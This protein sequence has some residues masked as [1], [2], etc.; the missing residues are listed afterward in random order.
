MHRDQ[1]LQQGYILAHVVAEPLLPLG[2]RAAIKTT[3]HVKHRQQRKADTCLFRRFDQR[4]RHGD[5]LSYLPSGV[6]L[7]DWASEAEKDP[8]GFTDRARESMA[9]HVEGM[10]GF[11]D[12]G[13]EVF[14]TNSPSRSR[15]AA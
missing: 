1:L 12:S 15:C 8:E 5:P 3:G 9:R 14:A 4:Q 13:A 7:E 6:A 11:Q 10:V 2:Q